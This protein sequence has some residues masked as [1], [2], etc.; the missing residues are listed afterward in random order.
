MKEESVKMSKNIPASLAFLLAMTALLGFG[1]PALVSGIAQLTFPERAGGSLLYI[2]GAPRGSRLLAQD[3]SSL[4]FFRARPSATGY[5]AVGAGASNLG[6]TSSDLATAVAE[7][8]AAFSGA[9]G[10]RPDEVPED[11]LYASA[12]GV[13]PDISL[14]AAL[15]QAPSVAAARRLDPAARSDL[16][17]EVRVSAASRAGLIGPPLVNVTMLNALL[18]SDPRFHR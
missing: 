4:R 18:E 10:I 15:A 5:A 7:R 16:E 12:S 2:D 3:F 8:R 9:F 13:D 17:A 6:P 14:E 11:M 1:Y